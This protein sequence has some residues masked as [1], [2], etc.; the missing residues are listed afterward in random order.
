MDKGASS[1]AVLLGDSLGR[2]GAPN[3][4]GGMR[5]RVWTW[6]GHV[7]RLDHGRCLPRVVRAKGIDWKVVQK[8][9]GEAH[10]HEHAGRFRRWKTSSRH[11][12]ARSLATIE[13]M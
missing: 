11:S 1:C 8:L 7:A 10:R 4:T 5:A 13:F 9:V 12:V 2:V 3:V 6:A